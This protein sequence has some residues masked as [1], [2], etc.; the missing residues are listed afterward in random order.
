MAPCLGTR[1]T[2]VACLLTRWRKLSKARA[3]TTGREPEP[4]PRGAPAHSR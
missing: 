2:P 3:R 1:R 4:A